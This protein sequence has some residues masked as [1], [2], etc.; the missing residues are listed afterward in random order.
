M[1]T[2]KKRLNISLSPDLDILLS[3]ISKR[4]SVPMATKAVYLLALALEQEEDIV[5]GEIA[6]K[7]DHK[8]ARFYSHKKAWA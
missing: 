3:R 8:K 5:L 2:T 4:D 7:R 6:K 1:P